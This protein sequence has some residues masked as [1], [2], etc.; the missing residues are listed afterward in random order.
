[1]TKGSNE[2]FVFILLFVLLVAVGDGLGQLV[3][4]F[5]VIE[6]NFG[7]SSKNILEFGDNA[8]LDLKTA[9]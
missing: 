4:F 9:V 7:L 6:L 5:A 3:E 2:Y 1:M 8:L